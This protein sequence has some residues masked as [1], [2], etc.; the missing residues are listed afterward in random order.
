MSDEAV[1]DEQGRRVVSG[2]NTRGGKIHP[3]SDPE[4]ARAANRKSQEARSRNAELR[5]LNAPAAERR[6]KRRQFARD[7]VSQ[8][9]IEE[10]RAVLADMDDD[11]LGILAQA[12]AIHTLSGLVTKQYEIRHATE[13]VTVAKAAVLISQIEAKR[14]VNG[15]EADDDLIGALAKLRGTISERRLA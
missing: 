2:P 4:V 6:E 15:A 8:N 13:A 3:F 9:G 11:S 1:Y 7:L 5:R 12:V 14:P 10:A